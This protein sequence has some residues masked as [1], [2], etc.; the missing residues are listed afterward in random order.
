MRLCSSTLPLPRLAFLFAGVATLTLALPIRAD[1]SKTKS[2][3]TSSGRTTIALEEWRK[4]AT[5]PLTPREIDDLIARE[6]G[7][8]VKKAARTTDEQF[9]RRVTLDLTGR[10]PTVRQTQDFVASKESDKR[11]RLIDQLLDSPEYARHW[12]RYWRA[13]I[14]AK[15]ADQRGQILARSFEV[16]MTEQL[17]ENKSWDEIVKAMLTVEGEIRYDDTGAKGMA[18]F[19]GSHMG[20]DSAVEQAAE[21]SRVFM[22]IQIQ[23]AQCHDHPSDVWKRQQF[24][25]FASYFAR[26]RQRLVR[27]KESNRFVGIE[28]VSLRFGEHR[29]PDKDNPRAGTMVSPRFLDGTSTRR[30]LSDSERRKELATRL[31]DKSNPWFSAAFVNRI[32]HELLGQGFYQPVDDLGPLKE[33][34][35]APV[36]IRLAGSFRGTNHDIKALYRVIL[37]TEAYQRQI[38]LG[39][40]PSEHLQFAASYPTRLR[41]DALWESLV[42]VLGPLGGRPGFG[43]GRPGGFGGGRFGFGGGLEQLFKQAFAYDPSSRPED[44][45]GS[46]PQALMLM[47]NPLI[48]QRIEA[49]GDTTLARL[50]RDTPKDAEAL[51]ILYLRTLARKPTERERQKCLTYIQKASSRSEAFEDILWALLNSTEFQTR[52]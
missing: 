15:L 39:D 50:L 22:G 40:S 30:G 9:I 7:A 1:E 45:E 25:E 14:A 32:W 2:K 29:M 26:V 5:T 46:V 8:S 33:A 34:V 37:N 52:R 10:L 47:N 38:R 42:G 20:A 35:M 28:L 51:E 6:L 13:V 31:T 44:I 19:L 48:Q 24:H 23:C 16:W 12:A 17:K 18:F 41:A 4:G 21:A 27:D 49:R 11:A 3:S 43:G 36:I